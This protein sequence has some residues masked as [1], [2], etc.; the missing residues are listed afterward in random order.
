MKFIFE[1]MRC[2]LLILV[3]SFTRVSIIDSEGSSTQSPTTKKTRRWTFSSCDN[4]FR[5]A[6]AVH[7]SAYSLL[8]NS[9]ATVI[10]SPIPPLSY[11]VRALPD[12]LSLSYRVRPSAVDPCA[13]IPSLDVCV[14][15]VDP[16]PGRPRKRPYPGSLRER[17][18]QALTSTPAPS[19]RVSSAGA[20][21]CAS[22]AISAAAATSRLPSK[23]LQRAPSRPSMEE[24]DPLSGR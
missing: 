7:A 23:S 10:S 2:T 3:T 22:A 15:A 19:V 14:S 21:I 13:P 9:L 1:A 5:P 4:R 6:L 8:G 17:R 12:P 20:D 24:S 11:R 18:P 16:L